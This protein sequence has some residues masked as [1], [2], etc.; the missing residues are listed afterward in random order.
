MKLLKISIFPYQSI[1]LILNTYFTSFHIVCEKPHDNVDAEKEQTS[2][3]ESE[4]IPLLDSESNEQ[5]SDVLHPTKPAPTLDAEITDQ[6]LAKEIPGMTEQPTQLT[7]PPEPQPHMSP[8]ENERIEE[9]DEPDPTQTPNQQR[10]P[11]S[12]STEPNIP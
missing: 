9:I 12:T 11:E 5:S 4:I 2:T 1:K 10:E 7:T 8:P 6:L 3:T